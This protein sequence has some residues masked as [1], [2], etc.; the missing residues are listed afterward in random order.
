MR[1]GGTLDRT[2]VMLA[3]LT[4]RGNFSTF[5]IIT[6]PFPNEYKNL[7]QAALR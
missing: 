7:L 1:A 3:E 6:L 2:T 4:A 5:F